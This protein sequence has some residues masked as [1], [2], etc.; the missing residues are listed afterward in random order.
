[1]KVEEQVGFLKRLS[2]SES[3]NGNNCLSSDIWECAVTLETLDSK[4]KA[5]ENN[6]S[7]L[8]KEGTGNG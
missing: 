6:I 7:E 2:R 8:M 3:H 4:V 1:M 5:L